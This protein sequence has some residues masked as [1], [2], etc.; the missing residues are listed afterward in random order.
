MS[1]WD[2]SKAPEAPKD[3][4]AMPL[5]ATSEPALRRLASDLAREARAS[6]ARSVWARHVRTEAHLGAHRATVVASTPDELIRQ[7]EAIANGETTVSRPVD[8]ADA[9]AVFVFGGLGGQWAGMGRRLLDSAPV[10]RAAIEECSAALEALGAG[11]LVRLLTDASEVLSDADAHDIQ[12]PAMV[13]TEIA[14]ARQLE[15]WGVRPTAVIGHSIGEIAAAHFA[16]ILSLPDAM[17]VVVEVGR[18]YRLTVR[19]GGVAMAFVA[20]PERDLAELVEKHPNEAFVSASNDP[21]ASVV[22][23][24]ADVVARW[25]E[26]W[27]ARGVSCRVLSR[28]A[29]HCPLAEPYARDLLLTLEN[30]RPAVARLPMM[31]TVTNEDVRGPEL[32]H[33]YWAT[34]MTSPVRFAEGVAVLARRGHTAFVDVSPADVLGRCVNSTLDAEAGIRSSVVTAQRRGEDGLESV[35]GCLAAAWAFGVNVD[36]RSVFG[37]DDAVASAPSEG[38][39]ARAVTHARRAP[40]APH[41]DGFPEARLDAVLSVVRSEVARILFL[42]DAEAVEPDRF[43]QDLGLDSLT[44]LDLRDALAKRAAAS[45]K[46][47]LAFEHP[48]ARAIAELVVEKMLAAQGEAASSSDDEPAEAELVQLTP[49]PLRHEPFPLTDIQRA[50]WLGRNDALPLGG[51]ATHLYLELDGTVDLAR[52]SSALDRLI[53]RHDMLR[54]IFTPSGEQRVLESVP[55]FRIATTDFRNE[56]PENEEDGLRG[57]R[58]RMSHEVLAPDTWPLF[59]VRA[60]LLRGDRV[61][62]H[63]SLDMLIM[64]VA[65]A[66][67][68][69]RE[70]FAFYAEPNASPTP[71]ALSFRDY[72]LAEIEHRSS[73]R[74]ARAKKYWEERLSALPEA[75]QLPLRKDPASVRN[76][77][78][79]RRESVLDREAW[80]R[81]RARGASAGLTPS[82]MLLTAFADVLGAWSK[83]PSFLVNLTV[84]NRLPFHARVNEVAGDFTSVNLLA[85][86]TGDEP[87]FEARARR[88]Q[89]QLAIDLDHREFSGLGVL[90]ALAKA[91]GRTGEVLAPI[92]FTSG[93]KHDLSFDGPGMPDL[94]LVHAISQTPQVL[95]DH[96]VFEY[97]GALRFN[98]DAVDDVFVDGVLDAMFDAYR[99]LLIELSEDDSRWTRAGIEILPA[100]Q[101]ELIRRTNATEA[102]TSDRLLHAP[103][104]HRAA[105]APDSLAVVAAE[106]TLTYGELHRRAQQVA[107]WLRDADA[108]PNALVAIVMQKGWEQIVAAFGILASGSAYLPIDANLPGDRIRYLLEDG[109]VTLV[110]TQ[111]SAEGDIGWPAHVRR[112]AVDRLD[113]ARWD[114][115]VVE[116]VQAP[117]DLAYVIYTS[118]S[119]G[120]P[121]GVMIDHRAAANTIDDINERFDVTSKDR[122]LALS[123]LSFDLSVYDLFGMVAVGGAI[124]VPDVAGARDPSHWADL[125]ASHRVTLWNTVPALMEM[126]VDHLEGLGAT[127]DLALRLVMMSG[128]WIPVSLPAR[129]K[130]QW[131]DA[132]VIS[133]G[134]ATEA[135]I[136]SILHPIEEVDPEWTSIPYGRAMRNQRMYV[137]KDNMAPC[138]VWVT[139]GL[140]IGGVGVARGYWNDAERTAR[141]F[142]RHPVTGERLYRTGDLG[143]Y[144]PDGTIEF[145]GRDDSQVKVRGHRIELGEI[146]ATLRRHP[147]VS[148]ALAV[149]WQGSVGG[150]QLAAY[151]VPTERPAARGDDGAAVTLDSLA[152]LAFKAEERALLPPTA[153]KSRI[154]LGNEQVD[155]ATRARYRAER[156]QRR[157]ARGPASLDQLSRLLGCLRA[158]AFDDHPLAKYLYPSAGH[159]YPVQTYVHVRRG[160]VAGLEGGSYYYHPREH[161]LWRLSEDELDASAHAPQNRSIAE[162]A[163]FGIFLIGA[164]DAIEPTYGDRARDFCLIEAGCMSQLLRAEASRLE[165]GL[166]PIGAMDVAPLRTL[167]GMEE[168]RVFLHCLLGGGLPEDAAAVTALPE[169]PARMDVEKELRRFLAEQLPSYMV[170]PTITV[171]DR[172]PLSANGKVDRKALP[173]PAKPAEVTRRALPRT[174]TEKAVVTIL[175]NALGLESVDVD[176]NFFDL[177]INSIQLLRVHAALCKHFGRVLPVVE[178]FRHARV[179][180]LAE[181]LSTGPAQEETTSTA[182]KRRSALSRFR[183]RRQGDE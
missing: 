40:W 67:L 92:V 17:L 83:T 45:I 172:L 30:V 68:L 25:L 70:L 125:V 69:G 80:Q 71:P 32:D 181:Y 126:L 173:P 15:A 7:L 148:E 160:R 64:D 123:S 19:R 36:W 42:R 44:A 138:P 34:N 140:Y 98:W 183:K 10:Y 121:K 31:S 16:G 150:K 119:T 94:E 23:G 1:A 84:F 170:P 63:L 33:R 124:V 58:A 81:L 122:V 128:D 177:G 146:E 6:G 51:V 137:L 111:S 89:Q 165:L 107:R 73:G 166:C 41:E 139:G 56:T 134:G 110:L 82:A 115:N 155:D 133:L 66:A 112:L 27:K 152:T 132:K 95:L 130:A 129:V 12:N 57:I 176:A 50:Y 77:R 167:F 147:Q 116:D 144:K 179:S 22:C 18:R 85:I 164:L 109:G 60:S 78:F 127:R 153:S 93:L 26:I 14:L 108:R 154:E 120:S 145:L 168:N 72:V 76:P 91:R 104:R 141:A 2:E 38:K 142:V 105:V 118:G 35:Y 87:S 21:G 55:P 74:Y 106:R 54:A 102:A 114:G 46:A 5:A 9:G 20:L 182:D 13:A 59:D 53:E 79:T 3:W 75:P 97:D 136:W 11:S 8:G 101:R 61:R 157:F 37:A 156:S 143:R 4:V 39:S 169:L 24:Q 52:L 49:S 131:P 178:M 149:A 28:V 113:P 158:L 135:A 62:L 99:A 117:S 29:A 65:S 43:L 96:Q 174:D 163:A 159:L 86:T 162:G 48:T 171:L 151:V 90:E 161:Q 100:A 47:T 88:L 103:L 180:T 175:C